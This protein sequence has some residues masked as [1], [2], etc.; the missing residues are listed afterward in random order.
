VGDHGDAIDSK[1]GSPSELPPVDSG[2]ELSHARPD[3]QTAE[4]ATH[5]LRDLVA[6]VAEQKLGG[7]LGHERVLAVA[8]AVGEEAA[9]AGDDS[10]QGGGR[11]VADLE[12]PPEQVGE[13]PVRCP[14]VPA[15][16]RMISLIEEVRRDRDSIGGVCELVAVGVAAGPDQDKRMSN[17]PATDRKET[18]TGLSKSVG[19]AFFICHFG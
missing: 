10:R 19:G 1:Q 5:G 2:A 15:A 11:V 9:I 12:V 18:G 17:V 4:L 6:E 7:G 13:T 14:G 3:Q 8:L 16:G